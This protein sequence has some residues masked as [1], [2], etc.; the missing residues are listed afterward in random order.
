[1]ENH[2]I[3]LLKENLDLNDFYSITIWKNDKDG[4][5]INLQ[6]NKTPENILKYSNMG[7]EFKLNN[8][9][10]FKAIKNKF[11]ITLT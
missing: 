4:H 8:G 10:W 2:L 6:G 11:I 3:D 7:F 1:M 9:N 5:H